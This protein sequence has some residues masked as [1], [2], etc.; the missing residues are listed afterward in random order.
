MA[1]NGA[2]E[3]GNK[4][5]RTA[6]AE[7][8][9]AAHSA[10][11]ILGTIVSLLMG[12]PAHRFFFLADLDWMIAPALAA[13]QFR[14]FHAGKL[15]IGFAAWATVSEEV[16]KE[17]LAGT[18]R[19]RP[20]DW[21]SGDRLWLIDLVAPVAAS[22]PKVIEGLLGELLRGP[23]EGKK[24]KMRITDPKTGRRRVAEFGPKPPADAVRTVAAEKLDES[25]ST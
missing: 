7:P 1:K 18:Q 15:P 11:D 6:D 17:M 9:R 16:E 2:S 19:L 23:F 25:I 10:A 5:Q 21:K 20:A 24:F 4:T 13:K 8:K 14:I 22:K 3:T 12:S